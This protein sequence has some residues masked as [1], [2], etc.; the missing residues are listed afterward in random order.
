MSYTFLL[1]D[2]DNTLLDFDQAEEAALTQLFRSAGVSDSHA[3]K[4]Y[5]RPLNQSLWRQLE[6]QEISKQELVDTR[7][8]KTFAHFGQQVDGRELARRYQDFLG[9]QGQLLEGADSL[10]ATLMEWGFSLYAA[11]NGVTAI[12][13][14]RLLHSSILPYFKQVFISE[15]LGTQ[16]PSVDFFESVLQQIGCTNKGEVLMIGDSLTAD[17]RGAQLAGID[18]IWYNPK[19]EENTTAYLPTYTV[20]SYA[21]LLALL[22][23][24]RAE[25]K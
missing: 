23:G 15:Q 11:T 25:R 2:L 1:F 21:E 20:A 10:L 7:F 19:Q 12:Q 22:Q 6:K 16:K 13:E 3:Y 9:Q 4:D 8:S 17:I 14:R 18:S 24:H 5:Y